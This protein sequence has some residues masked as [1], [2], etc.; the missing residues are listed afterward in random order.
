MTLYRAL[1]ARKKF[2]EPNDI[3]EFREVQRQLPEG[4]KMRV[5][6][7]GR[8]GRPSCGAICSAIGKTGVYLFGAC[9]DEGMTTN[10]SYLIQWKAIQWMKQQGCHATI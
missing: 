8:D 6:L 7:T 5:F 4:E 9:N 1:L 3:G 10:G 2:K